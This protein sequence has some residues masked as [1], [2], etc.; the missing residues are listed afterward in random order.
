MKTLIAIATL[1]VLGGC[2]VPAPAPYY[3]T[4]ALPAASYDPYQWHTVSVTPAQGGNPVA[5]PA[6]APSSGYTE[7]TYAPA[8]PVYV[9]PAPVYV[10]QPVYDPYFYAPV[11]LGLNFVIGGGCCRYGGWGAGYGWGR[12]HGGRPPVPGHGPGRPPRR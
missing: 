1:A 2:A 11:G 9:P 7:V 8:A 10:G 4:V 5:A 6:D 12:G 3:Q